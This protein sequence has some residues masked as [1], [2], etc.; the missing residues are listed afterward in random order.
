MKVKS[1]SRVR[2]S[3]T[4]WTV[5]FQVPPSMEFS[6]QDYWSGLPYPPPGDL[7]DPGIE[8]GLLHYKQMLY[9]LRHQGSQA[10]RVRAIQRLGG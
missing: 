10:W 2:L 9:H 7:P 3:A 6:R 5:A 1:L 8:P 4:P